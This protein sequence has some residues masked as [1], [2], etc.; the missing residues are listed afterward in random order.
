MGHPR[1][2]WGC[3]LQESWLFQWALCIEVVPEAKCMFQFWNL[4]YEIW[5]SFLKE[6]RMSL[7]W[8]V[9]RKKERWS[10]SYLQT[11]CVC[12]CID[13]VCVWVCVQAFLLNCRLW[14]CPISLPWDITSNNCLAPVLNCITLINQIKAKKSLTSKIL[15]MK[16]KHT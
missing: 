14:N 13:F 8:A 10:K 15:N 9:W 6:T 16:R 11:N 12:M 3:W 5:V 7:V 2:W 4:E 1:A